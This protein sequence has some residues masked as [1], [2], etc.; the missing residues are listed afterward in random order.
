[1]YKSTTNLFGNKMIEAGSPVCTNEHQQPLQYQRTIPAISTI[2]MKR[3]K[4]LRQLS[5]VMLWKQKTLR[6]LLKRIRL[7]VVAVVMRLMRLIGLIRLI[8]GMCM[9]LSRRC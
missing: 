1:M 4:S 8:R 2:T 5:E 7:L 3:Q 6:S 9:R